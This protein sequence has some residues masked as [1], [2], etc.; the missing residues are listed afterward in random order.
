M[1]EF[2]TWTSGQ[3]EMWK[4]SLLSLRLQESCFAM[5]EVDGKND[6]A[7]QFLAWSKYFVHK[8]FEHWRSFNEANNTENLEYGD[9]SQ[10]HLWKNMDCCHDCKEKLKLV[11]STGDVAF[12]TQAEY[13]EASKL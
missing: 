1:S 3:M 9:W 2:G 8:I 5:L 4:N 13:L 12:E 10:E 11:N 7:A 6:E